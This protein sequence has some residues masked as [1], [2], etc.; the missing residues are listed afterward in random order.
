MNIYEAEKRKELDE[1]KLH[2]VKLNI[3]SE[4]K[5][6][7]SCSVERIGEI[8]GEIN[9]LFDSVLEYENKIKFTKSV[10]IINGHPISSICNQI[11]V[12]TKKLEFYRD[13]FDSV[14]SYYGENN[15]NMSEVVSKVLDE[16]S[17]FLGRIVSD[18]HKSKVSLFETLLSTKILEVNDAV[19]SDKTEQE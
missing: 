14:V 10:V 17:E 18:L 1:Q 2:L 19:R 8:L 11:D 5:A 12:Y 3:S 16:I 15:I 7:E 4:L 6:N 9:T 13:V